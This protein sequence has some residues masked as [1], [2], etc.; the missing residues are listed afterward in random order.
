MRSMSRLG[1]SRCL[2]PARVAVAVVGV[3]VIVVGCGSTNATDRATEQ[4][5]AEQ[6]VAATQAAG[7]AP[8]LT[9]DLAESLYGTGAPTVCDV[10][11]DGLTTAERNDLW[12]NPTGRRAK[13]ITT[14]AITYGRLVV[15]VYC[16]DE[17]PHFD[18]AVASLDPV[19][20]D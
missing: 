14:D 15:E 7:V 17:L 8:H 20:S 11:A 13:I 5:R 9:I 6:L 1:A 2:L 12:G 10:F 3:A 18:A 16:P 19:K 4:Q